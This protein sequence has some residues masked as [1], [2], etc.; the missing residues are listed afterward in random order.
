MAL[1]NE[2]LS[3]MMTIKLCKWC[4][5]LQKWSL[6]HAAPNKMCSR[7][8]RAALMSLSLWGLSL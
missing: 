6:V 1:V 4:Q 5:M 7:C 8:I 2:L 3:L